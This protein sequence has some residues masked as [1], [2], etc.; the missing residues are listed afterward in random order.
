MLFFELFMAG[1]LTAAK[2]S[3][4]AD[5][6]NLVLGASASFWT[7]GLKDR[8]FCGQMISTFGTVLLVTLGAGW[9]RSPRLSLWLTWILICHVYLQRTLLLPLLFRQFGGGVARFFVGFE[10]F[11]IGLT[12]ASAGL[13]GAAQ[14]RELLRKYWLLPLLVNAFLWSPAWATRMD[15]QPPEQLPVIARVQFCE[16]LWVLCFLCAGQ[17]WFPASAWPDEL[18]AWLGEA[19]LCLFLLHN[20]VHLLAPEPINWLL[21]SALPLPF[22]WRAQGPRCRRSCAEP[23]ASKAPEI[24]QV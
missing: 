15:N 4:V 23:S 8:E 24:S 11:V 16:L 19:A 20:A 17:D 3:F 6:V 21:L 10:L 18:R 14:L 22:W 9:L 1:I 12:A 7:E 13:K 2:T 5:A